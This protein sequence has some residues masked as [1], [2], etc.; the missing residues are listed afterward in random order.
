VCR[1]TPHFRTLMFAALAA[2]LAFQSPPTTNA[3]EAGTA[4]LRS[5]GAEQGSLFFLI[6]SAFS[7]G[8]TG[9]VDGAT[10]SE[11]LSVFAA[12][13]GIV[14][15]QPDGAATILT[16]VDND[17]EVYGQGIAADAAGNFWFVDGGSEIGEINS[18]AQYKLF[19]PTT[20]NPVQGITLGS[21][22]AMWFSM[23]LS[24][25][26][27]PG[28]GRIANDG[29]ITSYP[30]SQLDRLTYGIAT[31]A[32][33][34]VWVS[35]RDP[36]ND[37]ELVKITPSGQSTGYVTETDCNI[38]IDQPI[39]THGVAAGPDGNIWFA[40]E[41][42]A[43]IGKIT[44]AGVV[45]FYPV[46]KSAPYSLASG[47][48]GAVWFTDALYEIGRITTSGVIT[49]TAVPPLSDYTNC[50]N[51]DV[52]QVIP[53]PSGTL[54]FFGQSQAYCGYIGSFVPSASAVAIH[55]AKPAS[56]DE[57][58]CAGD[59][60][61]IL[62]IYPES[63]EVPANGDSYASVQF[64]AFSANGYSVSMQTGANFGSCSA[65]SGGNRIYNPG[66]LVNVGGKGNLR[67]D[68]F[69]ISD[70]TISQYPLLTPG[71]IVTCTYPFQLIQLEVATGQTSVLLQLTL[72]GKIVVGE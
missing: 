54:Q 57:A 33:G 38:P 49:Y 13:Q 51:L 10:N 69:E 56:K 48:D 21:D 29:T 36:N 55:G 71:Q 68:A 30:L 53:G 60:V 59:M 43:G 23:D 37:E 16:P 40:S 52:T 27:G 28:I 4:K 32:D 66:Y 22:G 18:K 45:T 63:Q 12:P 19:Q 31:G 15:N 72:T 58:S 7:T 61:C 24:F 1:P 14:L 5:D 50:T 70:L 46:T 26:E 17:D 47:S 11:G 65:F 67:Y 62:R 35:G 20:G 44:P 6:P 41:C 34:N 2:F 64:T 9:Y 3:Q 25:Q 42:G 39:G 8:V